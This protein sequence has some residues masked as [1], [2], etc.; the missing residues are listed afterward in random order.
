MIIGF[1]FKQRNLTKLV[2]DSGTR[3]EN[4]SPADALPSTGHFTHFIDITG[5]GLTII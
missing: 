1:V 3:D 4:L 2:L 5:E